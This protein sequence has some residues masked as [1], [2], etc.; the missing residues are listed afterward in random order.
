[1]SLHD[2]G[3]ISLM[4]LFTAPHPHAQSRRL[5]LLSRSCGAK[6]AYEDEVPASQSDFRMNITSLHASMTLAMFI[7]K[8]AVNS[9]I[10]IQKIT[11]T[12]CHVRFFSL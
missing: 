12:H 10:L 7:L 11:K 8:S 9:N 3:I 4:L 1:M 2:G 5:R 6:I